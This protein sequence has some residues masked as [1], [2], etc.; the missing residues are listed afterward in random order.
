M[1]APS[2]SSGGHT[3]DHASGGSR[4]AVLPDGHRRNP[5]TSTATGGR[6]LSASQLWWFLLWP[7]RGFGVLT[8]TG[9][10]TGKRRRRCI[11]VV[12]VGRTAYLTAIG[13]AKA[14]WLRNMRANPEVSLRTRGAAS[15]GIARNLRADELD[16]ARRAYCETFHAFDR[17]EYVMHMRGLP[18]RERI[19][20]LHE[21]W[22]THGEPVAI[23]LA[24]D[25]T[26]AKT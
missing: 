7:P 22:F 14:Q 3:G 17:A 8:V 23:D 10:R 26:L 24:L 6:A 21:H 4:T 11:R 15:H 2:E 12:R 13:G 1:T 25:S 16:A 9:R 18:T 19:Q 5:L 20:A